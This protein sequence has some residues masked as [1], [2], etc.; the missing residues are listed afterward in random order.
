MTTTILRTGTA[1][2]TTSAG[3][4]LAEPQP[5]VR[6]HIGPDS[7]DQQVMLKTIGCDSLDQLIDQTIPPDIRLKQPLKLP[8]PRS[9]HDVLRD[10]GALAGQNQIYRSF[11]GQGYYGTITPAVILRNVLENP[12]WYTQYTPYQAEI[13]QGRLEAL[14][15]FQ[16]M[17]AELT[18]LPLASASL[19]DEA[20]AAAEAMAMCKAIAGEGKNRLI[21]DANTHP[22]TIAVMQT[23]AHSQGITLEI[24]R[25][26]NIT[27]LEL[28]DDLFGVLI[29]QP[30]SDGKLIPEEEL[31]KFVARAHERGVLIIVA[32]DLLALTLM[33][34][35][36]EWGAD[37]AIGSAQRFG[38]PMGF[39][40]PHA[41]FMATHDQHVRRMPGRLVGVS[42]DVHGEPALRLA[43][44][45]REQHIRREKATSNICTA[46]VLPAILASMYAVY[47]GPQG[48]KRIARRV[49]TLTLGLAA[50][51]QRLGHNIDHSAFFDTLR[52]RPNGLDAQICLRAALTSG[53]NLR[54]F[55]D[56]SIG[57]SLDETTTLREVELLLES[58]AGGSTFMLNVEELAQAAI[59]DNQSAIVRRQSPFLQHPVFNRY[60]SE[61]EMLRYIFKLMSR[62]LS[63]AQSMIPL[64][65]CTMKLNATTEMIPITWPGFA[66]LHPLAPQEQTR[67]YQQ[68]FAQLEKWLAAITGLRRVWLQPNAGSQGEY[69]GLLVIRAYHA[70]CNQSQRNICLIPTSAHGTNPASAVIAGLKVVAVKCDVH[71]NIDVADLRARA[72]EHADH[73]AC[74]MITY[75]STHGVFELPVREICQIIH[76]HGGQ[77]YMD[78]AN[79]NAQVGLCRP[80]DIGADVCHLNLHKTFCIPHGG[81][82][83]GVGPIA[84]A[85][86]LAR[87]LP[88]D[89]AGN[90]TSGPAALI[91]PVS[92]AAYGSASIL[93]ISWAYIAMMGASGLTQASEL[94]ILNA[95]YMA[96]RLRKH[97]EI[98]F[99]GNNGRCA[100][101]FIIDC[102][103]FEKSAGVKVE[104]IAKRLID[105]GFHAPTM[106]FPVPGTLMIEPTESESKR[107]LDRFCD[108]MISIRKEI[109][110]L[111]QGH[112]DRSDNLLINAPHTARH[113]SSDQWAHP[114]SRQAAAFPAPWLEDFKFW[115][116]VGR[117]DNPWG[118][119]NLVCSCPPMSEN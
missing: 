91:G 26:P 81:G 117:V 37:I 97:Y 62:D 23:R 95:N 54:D 78:G 20:T 76:D 107:E 52:V 29:Q 56:G 42:K 99:T 102:R 113:V 83:P 80:G 87:F 17:I 18:A 28:P 25:R 105:Y 89:H 13:S 32:T 38:T 92:A 116:H 3:Q 88:S 1:M 104:D 71:G 58:F 11:I 65:S 64:G 103:A 106:S 75:P 30:G 36:G 85:E 72:A 74:L 2:T 31:E 51:L 46:Q 111:E 21:V 90:S 35:P 68:L 27:E 112:S 40:G 63:L 100:H 10:L 60:H 96:Q 110:D 79:M 22:Q 114:Y 82:G 108:A 48:L 61:T 86:H 19:L 34:P 57:I 33:K 15:N 77:V 53:I 98:L 67:G 12:G 115:P 93:P 5:F 109:A 7:S 16:T 118:D 6:R 119:R 94:A 59:N 24:C 69:A 49:H 73:L 66:D 55:G 41:A 4:Y 8:A 44:Q 45:T 101:E 9:E 14:L 84:V 47:H 70:A 39:G 43:V 50:G